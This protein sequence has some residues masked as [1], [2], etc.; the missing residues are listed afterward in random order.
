MSAQKDDSR[1]LAARGFQEHLK[2]AAALDGNRGAH[3]ATDNAVARA[4]AA[5]IGQP[6][7]EHVRTLLRAIEPV[8]SRVRR[9]VHAIKFEDGC[10]WSK[11][12]L[13][14]AAL[15]AHVSGGL[16]RGACPIKAGESTVM[17]AVLDMDS[18]KGATPWEDMMDVARELESVLEMFGLHAIPFRSSGGNG[19]HLLFL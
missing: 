5:L 14:L 2:T 6:N 4:S 8:W 9:D 17:I 11:Q 18:H 1:K 7:K 13:D 10:R 15:E 12:P 16:A 3:Q 19:I